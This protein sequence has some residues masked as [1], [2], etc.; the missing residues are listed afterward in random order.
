MIQRREDFGLA[1]KA[2]QSVGIS[3]KRGRQDLDGDLTF[4]LR[5]RRPIHLPHAAFPDRRGD[6]VDADARAGGQGQLCREYNRWADANTLETSS[7]HLSIAA[8]GKLPGAT[9]IPLSSATAPYELKRPEALSRRSTWGSSRKRVE[10][11]RHPRATDF[12]EGGDDVYR[13][14]TMQEFQLHGRESE[15]GQAGALIDQGRNPGAIARIRRC[16]KVGL[17]IGMAVLRYA[18]FRS[19]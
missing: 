14:I 12:T 1:L 9:A 19:S 3:G 11:L 2:H 6:V 5:V 15:R 16:V 7:Q 17:G 8:T 4:Q 10:N 13:R 18:A